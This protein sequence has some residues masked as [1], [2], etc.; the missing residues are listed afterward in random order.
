M[1]ITV[2]NERQILLL[3][4]ELFLLLLFARGLGEVFHRLGQ[5][6]VVGEILAGVLL[7]PTVF[8]ALYPG[9][10]KAIF[11]TGDTVQMHMLEVFAWLG[12]LFLL[13]VAGTVIFT[14]LLGGL[15]LTVGRRGVSWAVNR[16]ERGAV[17]REGAV[18]AFAFLL[19]LG[20]AYVCERIGIHAVFGFFLA[21]SLIGDCALVS[22]QARESIG[23]VVM[24]VFSPLFFAT[25]GLKVNF[26]KGFDWPL[27]IAVPVVAAARIKSGLAMDAPDGRDVHLLFL[28]LTP[29]ADMSL[30]VKI[31]AGIAGALQE[32]GVRHRLLEVPDGQMAETLTNAFRTQAMG[33]ASQGEAA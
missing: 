19:A 6:A 15:S 29:A 3:L 13:M 25:I 17:R 32:S 8:G 14:L 4:A 20:L 22:A 31:L 18:M 33:G 24:S 16:I 12:S 1:E 27:V 26:L 21:G 10:Q 5:P 11:P 23:S 7:G 30:Q 9:L 28:I 2:L